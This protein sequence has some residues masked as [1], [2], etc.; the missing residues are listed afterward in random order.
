MLRV[1]TITPVHI[2]DSRVDRGTTL[3]SKE[4][5][6]DALHSLVRQRAAVEVTARGTPKRGRKGTERA[7]RG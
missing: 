7:T 6:E 3:T 1:K 4:F 5:S 2:G